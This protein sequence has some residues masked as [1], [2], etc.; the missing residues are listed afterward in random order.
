M[1]G[2]GVERGFSGHFRDETSTVTLRVTDR[3][4]VDRTSYFEFEDVYNWF[5][6]SWV[7]LERGRSQWV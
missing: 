6:G 1:D 2:N 4:E 3:A 5:S 7:G